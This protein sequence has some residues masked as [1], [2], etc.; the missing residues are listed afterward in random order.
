MKLLAQE[1]IRKLLLVCSI[2]VGTVVILVMISLQLQSKEFHRETNKILAGIVGS[3]IEKYPEAEQD[4]IK[5]LS[6]IQEQ[7][8]ENGMQILQKYGINVDEIVPATNL[9]QVYQ[10]TM[11]I[12]LLWIVLLGILLISCFAIYL[13]R[14]EKKIRA[15]TEYLKEIEKQQYSLKIQE[16]EEGELS[17]LQNEIYK[18]TVMLKE[19]AQKLSQDKIYLSN[20][21]S[22]I[23]HQIK[24]PLTSISVLL[25][26]LKENTNL[27][28]EK[29]QE[30]LFEIS[31]QIE[32]IHWL[33]ISLLKLSKFDAGTVEL[34][35]ETILIQNLIKE[36]IQNLSIPLEIK[37]QTI[38]MQ[39]DPSSSFIGDFHWTAEAIINIIKNCM[40]H[41][42]E[43]KTIQVSF[44]ENALFTQIIIKDS[45][46]G[47]AKEDLPYIF[48]RFYKGKNAGKDSF[49]IGL[50]LAKAIIQNQGGDISVKSKKGEGTTFFVTIYKGIH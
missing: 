41:T 10:K 26:I 34:K 33:V 15:I 28:E 13:Y 17:Y 46:E 9:E 23:S 16:N 45:G 24:T 30:F 37:N 21:L 36:V 48:Q 43:G 2:L 1:K 22:D 19:S 44:K 14:R 40:E 11:R 29:R 47:I 25:D 50:A 38:Q 42:E 6:T 31:R 7:T 20:A 27:P 35:K 39:G 18:I 4:I 12:M 49:G 5:Q 32:W 3:L 8:V